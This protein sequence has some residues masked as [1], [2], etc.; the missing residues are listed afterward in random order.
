MR[1]IEDC[2]QP[3]AR[4]DS[5]LVLLPP[6]KASLE[7]LLA[8]GMVA[9]VRQ[10]GLPLDIV[11][12]EV[13][14]QQVM[15][16]TVAES[17][18][19]AVMAPAL[20]AGY[21]QIWLAGISL[22]AF[23]ALHYAASYAALCGQRLA[24]IKLLAPYPGTA[25]ILQ[26]ITAAGGP[27]AWADNPHTSRQH[28]RIW[29]HWLC[30]QTGDATDCP[31]WLGLADEDRFIAGQQLLAGLLPPARVQR[32]AGEHNWPAW[33]HLWQHWLDHGPLAAGTVALAAKE[34]A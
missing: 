34:Q 23:N 19:Q 33:L 21:R 3:A 14:Y 16:G 31:V 5:L 2:C 15:A 1:T 6:A 12:A 4:A 29:W 17:L 9:A 10:R 25:D 22:G 20:A 13:G 30:R 26:E 11:L 27:R 24:G 18:Q 8:Q 28:E 7:D 32:T